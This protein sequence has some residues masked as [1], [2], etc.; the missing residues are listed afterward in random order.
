M[1]DTFGDGWN[2]N[3]MDVIQ[4]GLTIA[5]IGPTFTTGSGPVT[6]SVPLCDGPF[7]LF[8]NSGGSF[9]TEVG[10]SII[11]SFGQVI[12]TLEPFTEENPILL[13]EG[14]VDC[15]NPTCL[16]PLNLTVTN[17]TTNG[18]TLNWV[19]NGPT[20]VSWEIYA[21]PVGSPAPDATTVPTATTTSFPYVISGCI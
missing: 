4:N 6:V 13:F 17:I 9:T 14:I 8:W 21:V 12:Y 5:T 19:P 3:T 10:V 7:E 1:T 20:P 2:G 18:A 11:N 16:P 15:N